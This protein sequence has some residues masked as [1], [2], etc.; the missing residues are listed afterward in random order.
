MKLTPLTLLIP[1]C[2]I[3][4]AIFGCVWLAKSA[5]APESEK[6]TISA[7]NGVEPFLRTYSVYDTVGEYG[8]SPLNSKYV[9]TVRGKAYLVNCGNEWVIVYSRHLQLDL[10]K[11]TKIS[12]W[13]VATNM[14]AS[15]DK[16]R[17]TIVIPVELEPINFTTNP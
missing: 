2:G 6:Q 17:Y 8:G 11:E 14:T 15:H 10:P 12:G 3:S 4:A 16:N 7:I 13:F 1:I 9:N 5:I